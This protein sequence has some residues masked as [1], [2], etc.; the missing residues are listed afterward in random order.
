MT[1]RPRPGIRGFTL[2]EVLA[3][4]VFI[5]I[6]LPVAM[7]GITVTLQAT[8]NAR[9]KVEAAQLAEGKLNELLVIRDPASFN[10]SGDF[11]IDWPEYRWDSR[12]QLT[13]MSVY[14]VTVNVYWTEQNQ[15]RSLPL[16]TFIYPEQTATQS[17]GGAQ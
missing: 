10:A 17:T 16:T 12:G 14:E 6:V 8:A 11:G 1:C 15:E 2:V 3:T 9:H 13:E 7:R 4:L 5:G